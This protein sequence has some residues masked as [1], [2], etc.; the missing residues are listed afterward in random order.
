M[1]INMGMSIDM[2]MNMNKGTDTQKILTIF[3]N[4]YIIHVH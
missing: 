4:T 3:I 1:N 2:N